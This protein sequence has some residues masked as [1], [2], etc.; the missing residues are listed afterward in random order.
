MGKA[1]LHR[2]FNGHVTGIDLSGCNEEV[3]LVQKVTNDG[4]TAIEVMQYFGTSLHEAMSM[5]L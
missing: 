3:H 5:Y 1:G 2:L 4:G